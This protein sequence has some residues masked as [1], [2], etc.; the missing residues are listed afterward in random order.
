[1]KNACFASIVQEETVVG[2]HVKMGLTSEL[3][4][5]SP[6]QTKEAED[7]KIELQTYK[8]CPWINRTHQ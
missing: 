6:C 7:L 1:M 3:S 2:T 5:T 4:L 8:A